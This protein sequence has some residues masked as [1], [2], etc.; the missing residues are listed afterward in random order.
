MRRATLSSSTGPF[1]ASPRWL[2]C[3]LRTVLGLAACAA[4]AVQAQPHRQTPTVQMYVPEEPKDNVYQMS[5][6]LPAELRRVAVLPVAWE[7]SQAGLSQGVEML[8]PILLSEVIKTRKFEVVAVSPPDLRRQT[9]RLSC[10]DAEILP[11]DFLDSLRRVYGC[12][13]VLFSQLTVFRAYAPLAVGWRLKLVDVRTRQILWA[14]DEVFDAEQPEVLGQARLFHAAGQWLLH[15]PENDWRVANSP[16][17]F[18]QYA[19]AKSLAFLPN[20]KDIIKVSPSTTDEP[21]RRWLDK[22]PASAKKAY[23]N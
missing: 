3:A 18:G 4:L 20:R 10:S 12:D 11:A 17:Q 5:P 21:S 23:G 6:E 16:R 8:A 14:V 13:A 19:I 1:D 22:K 15:D 7:D 2:K 9:G